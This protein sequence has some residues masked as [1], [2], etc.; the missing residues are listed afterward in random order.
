MRIKAKDPKLVSLIG[1]FMKVYLPCVRNRDADTIASYKFSINLYI[2]YLEAT[3]GLTILTI[4][5]CDFNQKNIVA[6]LSWLV[7]ENGTM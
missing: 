5:S 1:E 4:Q 2:L 7:S 6:F 3:K